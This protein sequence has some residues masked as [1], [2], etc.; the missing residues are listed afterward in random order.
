M[1]Q[2]LLAYAGV[3]L[4]ALFYHEVIRERKIKHWES[5][6]VYRGVSSD[7]PMGEPLGVKEWPLNHRNLHV[8]KLGSYHWGYARNPG[9]V[10]RYMQSRV[11]WDLL[12]KNL[13]RADVPHRSFVACLVRDHD[14]YTINELDLNGVEVKDVDLDDLNKR[15]RNFFYRK[16]YP[17]KKLT[18]NLEIEP[19][20]LAYGVVVDGSTLSATQKQAFQKTFNYVA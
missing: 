8:V 14:E 5:W 1:A 6:E 3:G 12:C 15:M 2:N 9:C 20:C 18:G 17:S 16:V 11:E 13:T 7:M 19:D 4:A 10:E